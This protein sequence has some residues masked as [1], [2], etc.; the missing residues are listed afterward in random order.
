M[1]PDPQQGPHE[2]LSLDPVLTALLLPWEP[3]ANQP[4]AVW[5]GLKVALLL[6]IWT[7]LLFVIVSFYR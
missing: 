1:I 5:D 4:R 2:R 7:G 3:P 6:A